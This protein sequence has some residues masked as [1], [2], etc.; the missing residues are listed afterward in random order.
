MPPYPSVAGVAVHGYV[1][2]VFRIFFLNLVNHLL[3][4]SPSVL[5]LIGYYYVKRNFILLLV[6]VESVYLKDIRYIG[7]NAGYLMSYFCGLSFAGVVGIDSYSGH[8]HSVFLGHNGSNLP[9]QGI[10]VCSV[11]GIRYFNMNGTQPSVRSVTV[12]YK[13]IGSPHIVK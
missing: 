3:P 7:S 4:D 2:L 8:D 10:Y 12:H 1:D 5:R 6:K 11:H 9:A 13:V